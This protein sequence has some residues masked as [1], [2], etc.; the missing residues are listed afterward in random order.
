MAII[1]KSK[2]ARTRSYTAIT[3][4]KDFV[5]FLFHLPNL[6]YSFR[7][8]QNSK[9]LAILA[10]KCEVLVT[11]INGCAMCYY[12]H[13]TDALRKGI[14]NGELLELQNRNKP[15]NSLDKDDIVALTF[16]EHYADSAGDIDPLALTRLQSAYGKSMSRD[17]IS[18]LRMVNLG[19][20]TGNTVENLRERVK[21]NAVS[22]SKFHD[23]VFV[24]CCLGWMFVPLFGK[25]FGSG[26]GG[27]GGDGKK[28]V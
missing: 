9:R 1:S 21:G 13:A 8:H 24:F 6:I 14:T 20:R 18:H 4:T 28:N 23:E 7:P 16:A 5:S 3:F 26:G 25:R 11:E 12:F 17:L 2:F 22:G 15:G 27:G 19:T 10:K